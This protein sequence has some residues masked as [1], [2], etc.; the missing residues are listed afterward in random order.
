MAHW[1][2]DANIIMQQGVR[3]LLSACVEYTKG[4]SHSRASTTAP[5]HAARHVESRNG[6]MQ[7]GPT[8]KVQP[9]STS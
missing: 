8:R 4:R 9:T 1:A 3:R 7:T 6:T 2:I 5:S